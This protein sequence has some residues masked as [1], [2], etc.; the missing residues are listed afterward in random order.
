MRAFV[1]SIGEPTTDL[2]VWS[3]RRNGFDVILIKDETTLWHKLKLIYEY[4]EE[5][6]FRVD[7]DIIVNNRLTPEMLSWLDAKNPEIWWWQFLTFDW[8]KLNLTH[9]MSYIRKE[10]IPA[11]CS[12]IE[13]VERSNRPETEMSRIKEFYDPR[14][15]DTYEDE[16]MGLHGYKADLKRVKKIKHIRNQQNLYDF[17]MA[18]RLNKL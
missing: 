4:A 11:L 7:A 1:T 16:I 3:L 5:D 15:F 9:S 14:R 6:F 17:E 8:L 12:R 2:C 18:E 13:F 10:A